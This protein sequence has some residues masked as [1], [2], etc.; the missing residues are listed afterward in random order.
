MLR[1]KSRHIYN[2]RER[3]E[4]GR[5]ERREVRRGREWKMKL[6]EKQ[7]KTMKMGD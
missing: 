3:G 2:Y 4:V 1:C 5:R 7:R 6:G